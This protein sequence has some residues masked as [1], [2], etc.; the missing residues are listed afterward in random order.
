MVHGSL[1]ALAKVLR[2]TGPRLPR[3][4]A[5][6]LTDAAAERIRMLLDK[7][8]KVGGRGWAWQCASLA[9]GWQGVLLLGWACSALGPPGVLWAAAR[10][11][12]AATFHARV[13]AAQL[14]AHGGGLDVGAWGRRRAALA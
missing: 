4:K 3:K 11:A 12:G 1:A 2:Q 8:H 9:V 5:V 13:A 14:C 7:R 10:P 6:E